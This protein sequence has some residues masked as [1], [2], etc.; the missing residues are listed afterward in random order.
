MRR[1]YKTVLGFLGVV[2][3]LAATAFAAQIPES[4]DVYA[5]SSASDV[6]LSFTINANENVNPATAVIAP[7]NQSRV[8]TNTP[9]VTVSFQDAVWLVVQIG[10]VRVDIIDNGNGEVSD[11]LVDDATARVFFDGDTCSIRLTLVGPDGTVWETYIELTAEDRAQGYIDITIPIASD[12]VS[13]G[14]YDLVATAYNC[15]GDMLDTPYVTQIEV[16]LLL[17]PATGI[18]ALTT[19]LTRDH[20]AIA[21]LIFIAVIVFA[22]F[23]VKKQGN[24][25]AASR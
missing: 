11:T 9:T 10:P 4:S 18:A 23:I 6:N 22:I 25:E 14:T 19:A 24:R 8:T 13:N 1:F 21:L 7:A 16:E 12:N 5:A 3:T 15:T 2:L 20:T 17:P